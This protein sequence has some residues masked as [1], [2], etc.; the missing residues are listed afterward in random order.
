MSSVDE[1]VVEMKFDNGQFENGIK[2]S[3]KSLENLDK[4][5]NNGSSKKSLSEIENGVGRISDRFSTLGIVATTAIANIANRLTNM[6]FST[7]KSFTIQPILDGFREYETKIN[8]VQ[9]ILSNTKS[10]G[11][12]LDDI[13]ASLDELNVYA[14]KTIY[15]FGQM[16]DNIGKFTAAGVDLKTAT[17]AV[18]GLSN[19]AALAGANASEQARAT[20]QMSQA[21]GAGMVRLQDWMSMERA[22]MGGEQIQNVLK[23]TAKEH[24]VAIDELIEKYGSFRLTLSEN[25]LTADIFTES[26]K[27]MTTTGVTE[28]MLEKTNLEKKDKEAIANTTS[29]LLEKV[30]TSEE[31]AKWLDEA[32]NIMSKHV[33]MSK[34]DIKE[35]LSLAQA[36]QKSATQVRTFTQLID[37]IKESIGS[38]WAK[39]FE[40]ILGD[41]EDAKILFT[42]INTEVSTLVQKFGDA[43]NQALKLWNENEN[44]RKAFIEGISNLYKIIKAPLSAIAKGFN[45]VFGKT[46]QQNADTLINLSSKFRDWTSK[47]LNGMTIYSRNANE[48]FSSLTS[49]VEFFGNVIKVALNVVKVIFKW[50]GSLLSIV[51][52][53]AGIIGNFI[54]SLFSMANAAGKSVNAFETINEI[55]QFIGVVGTSIFRKI[56]QFLDWISL[57]VKILTNRMKTNMSEVIGSL[58]PI[59]E[60]FTKIHEA[61]QESISQNSVRPFIDAIKN[62][63]PSLQRVI[64]ILKEIKNNIKETFSFMF[65]S[66][67]NLNS[68]ASNN[69]AFKKIAETIEKT[70][71]SAMDLSNALDNIKQKMDGVKSATTGAFKGAF[72]KVKEGFSSAKESVTSYAEA[73]VEA[74]KVVKKDNPIGA[75]GSLLA[76]GGIALFGLGGFKLSEAISGF[77]KPIHSIFDQAAKFGKNINGILKQ[78][79]NTLKAYQSQLRAEALLKIAGAIA[80]LAGAL[81]LLST[82]PTDK[83]TQASVAMGGIAGALVGASFALGQIGKSIKDFKPSGMIGKAF[84]LFLIAGSFATA[85]GA[86]AKLGE[87]DWADIA[88]GLAGMAGAIA[89]MIGTLEGISVLNKTRSKI[90]FE[91]IDK[92]L[93]QMFFL[94]ISLWVVAKAIATMGGL[95]FG[96]IM[97]GVLA[98]S[99]IMGMFLVFSRYSKKI[100][101][102]TTLAIMGISA[103]LYMLA[104]AVLIFALLPIK[105]VI[106]GLANLAASIG[107]IS[108]LIKIFPKNGMMFGASLGVVSM[109]L[110][111]FAGAIAVFGMIPVEVVTKALIGISLGIVL[112]GTALRAFP[113]G[114]AILVAAAFLIISMALIPLAAAFAIFSKVRIQDIVKGL[115]AVAGVLLLFAGAALLL[116][117]VIPLMLALAVTIALF[118]AAVGL[119]GLAIAA[120]AFG[121]T[122]LAGA[123]AAG[124]AAFVA[125]VRTIVI[126]LLTL[127]PDVAT[128]MAKGFTKFIQAIGEQ[129]PAIG[130][131][132]KAIFRSIIDTVTSMAS[133]V[134]ESFATLIENV[135]KTLQDH[136][137]GIV[138]AGLGVVAAF[139]RG[140][141]AGAKDIIGAVTDLILDIQQAIAD[142]IES[143]VAGGIE[144]AIGLIEG[145]AEALSSANERLATAIEHLRESIIGIFKAIFGIH[146]PSKVMENEADAL[147]DGIGES[148]FNFADSDTLKDAMGEIGEGIKSG[149]MDWIDSGGVK[150]MINSLSNSLLTGLT[151]MLPG[152]RAAGE[153]FAK[154]YAKSGGSYNYN[155]LGS[156][157]ITGAGQQ[158]LNATKDSVAQAQAIADETGKKM[159][160]AQ[161]KSYLN[162]LIK[163][164]TKIAAYNQKMFVKD[165]LNKTIPSTTAAGVKIAASYINNIVAGMGNNSGKVGTK[166]KSVVSSAK[167]SASSV[168]WTSI[169]T[170]IVN[171]IISGMSQML[172]SVTSYARKLIQKT[173]NAAKDEADINSP[174][175]LFRDEIGVSIPEGIAV[176]IYKK[177]S[178]VEDA[179]RAVVRNAAKSASLLADKV[180]GIVE[181]DM[182]SSPVITPVVD[183]T[184]V[185]GKSDDISNMLGGAYAYAISSNIIANRR[186]A[187]DAAAEAAFNSSGNVVNQ[188]NNMKIVQQPGESMDMFVNRVVGKLETATNMEG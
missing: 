46:V 179:S 29:A 53:I 181:N 127:I 123:S 171:G 159:A 118:G 52:K 130:Q 115:V 5:L 3:M 94:S 146:S 174:S 141:G 180:S 164:T 116:G 82:I 144:I 188:Y 108:A 14:D 102:S 149:F 80:V 32:T 187:Q 132:F 185:I 49:I 97:Q 145:I 147:G 106:I 182:N 122:V 27:K 137:G 89:I 22:G 37:T 119:F 177:A 163:N 33:D 11:T 98:L 138:E 55:I 154:E 167:A 19:A 184:D 114:K 42:S 131:A 39:T 47:I 107:V 30:G 100:N 166:A 74:S 175:R 121:F 150:D 95:S 168:G 83:L 57:K 75:I 10:K 85:A 133:D 157:Q 139:I 35:Y 169:G 165:V 162:G 45:N 103:S 93:G 84:A 68:K 21:L 13:T 9:T 73:N 183:L 44:G 152:M 99:A 28:W 124:C 86:L 41:F 69:A 70:R 105:A 156:A 125:S 78:V 186:R 161:T 91:G 24:G 151:N 59:P 26:M 43:R 172:S 58:G 34:K 50:I 7:M 61:M 51:A 77:F 155:I 92:T 36:A 62:I 64:D 90:D 113:E 2:T 120:I 104:G 117:P 112:I 176:G 140:L 111:L 110:Y 72:D 38:E 76:G 15:N 134:A 96:Q 17:D 178:L 4:T 87:L 6:L 67:K 173:K 25:W 8:S 16:T 18:Q 66:S 126:G 1:R 160:E 129:A 153:N 48:S 60:V 170:G 88:Q 148:L 71:K 12:T 128:A 54:G 81:F 65:K 56:G 136:M 23:K 79:S 135:L 109:A 63:F 40:Y 142:S 143:F 31:E 158:Y 101:V 20:Y